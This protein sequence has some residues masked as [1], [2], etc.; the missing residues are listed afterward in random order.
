MRRDDPIPELTHYQRGRAVEA[1]VIPGGLLTPTAELPC[2]PQVWRVIE[3][4]S[5]RF[6]PAA[7]VELLIS[8]ATEDGFGIVM[9]WPCCLN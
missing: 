5:R 6:H 3:P 1:G 4:T 9:D 7:V 2:G 8:F